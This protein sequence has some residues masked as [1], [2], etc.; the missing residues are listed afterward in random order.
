LLPWKQFLSVSRRGSD[1]IFFVSSL[2]SS[3]TMWSDI[4]TFLLSVAA[5]TKKFL[6]INVCNLVMVLIFMLISEYTIKETQH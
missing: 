3:F 4:E 2:E 5:E 1:Y 6:T